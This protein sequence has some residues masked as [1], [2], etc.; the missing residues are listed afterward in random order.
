M[1]TVPAS[2]HALDDPF[3][4]S[5]DGKP[6][7]DNTK[8]F[9]WIATVAGG[10][11]GG[12]A[13]LFDARPDVL[14][15]GNC[16]WYPVEGVNTIRAAPDVMVI[17]GRPKGYR[18]SYIQYREE[19][20]TP[21]VA[22]EILSPGNRAGEMRRKLAFYEQY[23]IQEY[24][25]L[26]PDF[27]KHKGYQRNAAGKLMQVPQLFGW[28][29]P[30]LGVRFEMTAELG[31]HSPEGRRIEFYE[32]EA[33]GRRVAE[34]QATENFQ[35]AETERQRAEV[36]RQRAE[37]E[38]LRADLAADQAEADRQARQAADGQVERLRA[39]LRALGI[40]PDA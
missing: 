37:A 3:Y 40:D 12:L 34:Q 13:T 4:R 33:I 27:E 6:M 5:S 15:T 31:I 10:G 32:V 38:R 29:S 26:D 28:V 7:A 23:G 18:G 30:L 14:V 16:L 1:A 17:F 9:E 19:G 2:I 24:Y 8:Q 22:F 20:V 25:I 11:G 39:Q 36:E 35:Q 21:Q